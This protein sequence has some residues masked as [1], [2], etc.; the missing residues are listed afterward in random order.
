[1]RISLLYQGVISKL[2]S[3]PKSRTR[4]RAVPVLYI[5]FALSRNSGMKAFPTMKR[6]IVPKY[7]FEIFS[8]FPKTIFPYFIIK[9]ELVIK[10]NIL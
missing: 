1:M 7:Y 10:V 6:K 8:W 5:D 2:F 3:A 4:N 9:K